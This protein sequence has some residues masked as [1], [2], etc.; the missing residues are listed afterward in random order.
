[1]KI[2]IVHQHYV[3][4]RYQNTFYE[5]KKQ[6]PNAQIDIIVPRHFKMGVVISAENPYPHELNV[7][8]LYAPFAKKGKQHLFFFI[9]L[10]KI[11]Q[12]IKPDIIWAQA[13]NSL[14]TFQ[15]TRIAKKLSIPVALLRFSNY[16]RDYLKI[17]NFF[18]PRR[19]LYHFFRI[20][21]FWR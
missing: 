20:Y 17:Y 13:P 3:V 12:K 2:L 21:T 16:K 5:I 18:D 4:G 10:K 14:N 6:F 19:Y 15:V 8:M 11:I 1:M 7:H 9:G